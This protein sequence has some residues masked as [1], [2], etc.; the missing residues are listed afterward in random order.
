MDTNSGDACTE[1]RQLELIQRIG[2]VGFW[3]F[4]TAAQSM[5]L[6]PASLDLLHTLAASPRPNSLLDVL[7]DTERKRL[8]KTLV[9][10]AH[11]QLE[12]SLEVKVDNKTEDHAAMIVRG[13]PFETSSG[14]PMFAGTFQDITREKRVE[15]ERE[16]VI[17]QLQSLLDAL[18][19]GVSVIDKDLRLVL[20][21]RRFHEILDFPQRLVYRYARFEDFVRFN[22]ERGEYGPGDPEDKVLA[23]VER[24][25][26]FEAHKF[27]RHLTGGGTLQVD[28]FPFKFSGAISGF[29]TIYTD[30]SERKK[31]E[32]QLIRQRDVMKTI[33]DNFP[34]AISLF[35]SDLKMAACNE[36]FK[37]LLELPAHLF[38]TQETHFEDL[39][40]FNANRGEYGPGD[41]EVLTAQITERARNFTAH[42]IERPRHDGQWLEIRGT[43]IP[44]GGFVTSY[45]DITERKKTEERI[46]VLALQD[47]LTGLPNRLHLNDQV[48]QALERAASALQKFAILFLDLDGFKKVN[49]SYG[50]DMGDILLIHVAQLLKSAVRETDVAAR[51]GGDEFVVLLHDVTD[52]AMVATVAQK[53]V[54][55]VGAPCELEGVQIT[56]GASIGIAI[57]PQDGETREALLKAADHAMYAAKSAGKGSYRFSSAA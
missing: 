10:A 19:Q 4:N 35:D 32:E 51:L 27:E 44:S 23:Q 28:G 34:G 52:Q 12:F 37:T 13:A 50:H 33:I 14:T 47:A 41:T 22:A 48:E 18:P 8:Q 55:S 3:E 42:R 46:R 43:P 16:E 57:Y 30:I 15:A 2:R 49:D 36:Q 29:V 5:V 9:H 31:T 17:T 7:S 54:Q 21:N 20:W 25:K 38:A 6:P 24:A 11:Q 53:I 39:I 45:I 56:I 1:G 40:R 26:K